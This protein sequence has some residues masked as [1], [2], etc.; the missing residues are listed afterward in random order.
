MRMRETT[1]SSQ[2]EKQKGKGKETLQDFDQRTSRTLSS[3]PTI[4]FELN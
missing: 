4:L 2:V 3:S 1:T